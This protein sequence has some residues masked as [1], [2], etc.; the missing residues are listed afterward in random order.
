MKLVIYIGSPRGKNGNTKIV[1][2]S[3]IKGFLN[4]NKDN[5]VELY[6]LKENNIK[7]NIKKLENADS[8]IIAFPLYIHAMP[9]PVKLFLENI[10]TLNNKKLGFIVQF[11]YFESNQAKLLKRYLDNIYKKINAQYLGTSVKGNCERLR[12]VPRKKIKKIRREYRK[13][14][15]VFGKTALFNE[16]IMFNLSKPVKIPFIIKVV[17]I[18]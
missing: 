11:G 9:S 1:I 17:Y 7:E 12:L 3:F 5:S 6:Y 2:N 15:Y 4:A 14:G 18:I 16:Q 10:N 8:I 13:F